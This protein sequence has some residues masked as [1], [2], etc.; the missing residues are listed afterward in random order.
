MTIVTF[1]DFD[2]KRVG[3]SKTEVKD[4]VEALAKPE[5]D[6]IT[7]F[8]EMTRSRDPRITLGLHVIDVILGHMIFL[9]PTGIRMAVADGRRSGGNRHV[10]D[11]RLATAMVLA[12]EI[13]HVNQEVFHGRDSKVFYGKKRSRHMT[14]PCEMEARSFADRNI[15]VLSKIIGVELLK[16]PCVE[17]DV[18]DDEIQDIID[19]LKEPGQKVSV[20]DIVEE[21]RLSNA[22]NAVNVKRV[23]DALSSLG[24]LL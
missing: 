8:G 14:R 7:L 18:G 6:F 22:N 15:D 12:H 16:N 24:L 10:P 3:L 17:I 13:Q 19:W 20:S 4:I 11:V 23:K 5:I 9:S 1:G 21:L 2:Q